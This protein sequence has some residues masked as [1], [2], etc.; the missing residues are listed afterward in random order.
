MTSF[1]SMAGMSRQ[2]NS[3]ANLHISA[4]GMKINRTHMKLISEN[5]A[6][7][8]STAH[9]PDRNPYRRKMMQVTN[10]VD[11]QLGVPLVQVNR[12]TLDKKDF[13]RVH[14][15]GD[16]GADEKGFVKQSNVDTVI[17]NQDMRQAGYL[18]RL[19]LAAYENTRAMILGVLNM[20]A[21]SH[22]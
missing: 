9:S 8:E 1:I 20:A 11:P 4:A 3:F 22:S 5:I 13:P 10:R 12:F 19:N 16:P 14:R 7:A 18:Y 15:P 17:E 6:N 21:K 2:F